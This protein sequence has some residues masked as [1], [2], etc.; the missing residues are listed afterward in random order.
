[1]ARDQLN[2]AEGSKRPWSR[3]LPFGKIDLD[4]AAVAAQS[5]TLV[6]RLAIPTDRGIDEVAN[7]LVQALQVSAA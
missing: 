6:D 5:P 1:M 7:Q 3:L 4:R 2:L